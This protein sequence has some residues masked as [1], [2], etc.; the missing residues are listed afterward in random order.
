MS[1]KKIALLILLLL[2][3]GLLFFIT[4]ATGPAAKADTTAR[5]FEVVKDA[6]ADQVIATLKKQ[7]FIKNEMMAKV[8]VRLTKK[9]N[10]QAGVYKLKRSDNLPAIINHLNDPANITGISLTFIEGKRITDYAKVV[11]DKLG[12]KQELFLSKCNDKKFIASLTSK[13]QLL[14]DYR[15]ND[16]EYYLLEG[17]LAP[18]TYIVPE[19][20]SVENVIELMVKQ[21]N[22]IYIQ[23]SAAFKKSK[24]SVR[25]AYTLASIVELEANT[26]GDRQAVA[27]VFLNRLEQQMSLG[28]DVTTYYG[29]KLNV[30]DRDLTSAELA[31]KNGY[32]TR[33][34]MLGLPIGPIGNPSAASIRAVLNP[35]TNDDLYFVSDK[36]GKIYLAKTYAEHNKIIDDLKA[37]GLWFTYE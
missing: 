11:E 13:Y 21:A 36:N 34:G 24:L 4:Y 10:M 31:Q 5:N 37:K 22:D 6:S 19:D 18:D 20:A 12:I 23:N 28:S 26:Y 8:Y 16:K 17:I 25:D 3:G 33:S 14:K 32:N 7:G 30:A 27:A 1:K 2:I 35:A 15:F 9:T 29:L